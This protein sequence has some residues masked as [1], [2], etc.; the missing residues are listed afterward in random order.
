MSMF[1]SEI[2]DKLCDC[3]NGEAC[4]GERHGSIQECWTTYTLRDILR[5]IPTEE[6]VEVKHGSWKLNTDGYYECDACHNLAMWYHDRTHQIRTEFCPR[7]GARM[8]GTEWI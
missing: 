3:C 4:D 2:L 7:C 5:N 1:I 8:D 6:E